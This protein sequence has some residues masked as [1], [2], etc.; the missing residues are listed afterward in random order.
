MLRYLHW[1]M[2]KILRPKVHLRFIASS[3]VRASVC[4]LFL[5]TVISLFFFVCFLRK[6][7]VMCLCVCDSTHEWFSRFCVRFIIPS[8]QSITYLLRSA[9]EASLLFISAF[10]SSSEYCRISA[11]LKDR[12][13]SAVSAQMKDK[14][15]HKSSNMQDFFHLTNAHVN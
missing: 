7:P 14:Q 9:Y 8:Y 11:L 6:F 10:V 3:S 12:S 5:R 2:T 1:K 4:T 15:S 13:F